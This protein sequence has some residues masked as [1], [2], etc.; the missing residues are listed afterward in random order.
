MA[1]FDAFSAIDV[2][3]AVRDQ[4]TRI[5]DQATRDI[6]QAWSTAWA[7]VLPE[8]ESA[9]AALLE[10]P[11]ASRM[12]RAKRTSSA[13]DALQEA[14]TGLT[15]TAGVTI[16]SRLSSAVQAGV[17]GT[18]RKLTAQL[19]SGMPIQG[20]SPAAIQAMIARSTQQVTSTL[21]PLA[22]D[23]TA[24]MKAELMRGVALGSN[25]TKAARRIIGRVKERFDGGLGRALTVA[26]TEIL[27]AHRA[28]NLASE[29][30]NREAL[31]GW[32]WL[33]KLD[34]TTCRA[35]IGMHGRRFP[36]DQPGP[37]GHQNCRCARVPVTKSWAD[38]GF[39]GIDEAPNVFPDKE[40]WFNGLTE[41]KQRAILGND[42]EAW[43]AGEFPMSSWAVKRSNSG[44]RDS[45][46]AARPGDLD[47]PSPRPYGDLDD[48]EL[49][50]LMDQMI[51]SGDLTDFETVSAILD[52][53]D[54][55]AAA[56]AADKAWKP[57]PAHYNNAQT[58][59]W[60]DEATPEQQDRFLMA[61]PDQDLFWQ[62][63]YT[64]L[65]GKEV[66]AVKKFTEAE[67]REGF[68]LELLSIID[69]MTNEGGITDFVKKTS[70]GR[71][72]PDDLFRVSENVAWANATEE[73]KDWWARNGGRLN[74][75]RY[76]MLIE[77][78]RKA[79]EWMDKGAQRW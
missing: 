18:H 32:E 56:A 10:D 77:N 12:W 30:A 60:F 50:A 61:L 59:E 53:R 24:T 16:T 48:T 72:S 4:L 21:W 6:V 62:D 27:D 42:F 28:A 8:V 63:R 54:Q 14:L 68:E 23:V 57:D 37:E 70:Q 74:Y 19:P 66:R 45:W 13:V 76:K 71:Y 3:G 40:K 55:A 26:R 43:Q 2:E 65:T 78:P 41:S 67:M 51:E 47:V 25:P 22:D 15:Q 29:Q 38:L 20:A 52:A 73:V 11:K 31:D 46:V 79:R 75:Q 9:A 34:T 5:T 36:I 35:C 39:A 17:D 44:W 33:A 58:F 64:H 69:R 7:A 1:S 49:M